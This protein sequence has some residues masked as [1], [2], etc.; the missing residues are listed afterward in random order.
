MNV[1]VI[2][3]KRELFYLCQGMC[4]NLCDFYILKSFYSGNVFIEFENSIFFA[5][6]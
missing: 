5:N 4:E 6:T 1:T 3:M 2:T